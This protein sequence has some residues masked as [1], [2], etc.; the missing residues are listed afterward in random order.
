M[1]QFKR[2]QTKTKTRQPDTHRESNRCINWQ[3]NV[4]RNFFPSLFF[5]SVALIEI[6]YRNVIIFNW[7]AFFISSCV[8][9]FMLT[10]VF[11][12]GIGFS[13][14]NQLNPCACV[15]RLFIYFIYFSFIK[16]KSKIKNDSNNLWIDNNNTH[17]NHLNKAKKNNI[18]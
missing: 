3:I 5:F 2:T 6:N 17:N 18:K 9:S 8:S 7:T 13:F 15:F 14:S 16:E 12:F 1:I 11:V 10:I 4:Y